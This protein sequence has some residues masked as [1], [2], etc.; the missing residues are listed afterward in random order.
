MIAIIIT[1]FFIALG[2]ITIIGIFMDTRRGR[3]QWPLDDE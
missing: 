2:L 1:G 3:K